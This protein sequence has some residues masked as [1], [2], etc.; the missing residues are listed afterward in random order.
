MRDGAGKLARLACG[1]L[2]HM[3]QP[4]LEQLFRDAGLSFKLVLTR[5][6]TEV[7]YE[8]ARIPSA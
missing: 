7:T 6:L 5:D 8:L 4:E 1:W 2:N 3:T